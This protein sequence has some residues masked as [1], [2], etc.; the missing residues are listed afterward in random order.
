MKALSTNKTWNLAFIFHGIA[1]GMLPILVPLYFVEYLKGSVL[2]FGVMSAIATLFS[3]LTSAYA[4]RLPEAYGRVKPFILISFLLSSAFLFALARTSNIY[5]FQILYVLLGVANSLYPSSA[6]ILI[7]ETYQKADWSKIF[8]QHNLI[9]GLSN[10]SGLAICSLYVTSLG[11]EALLLICVPLVLVS[12]LL[13]LVVVNDP[14]FYVERLLSRLSRV[15]A[16]VESFSYWLGS[17]GSPR[18]FGLKPTVNMA[19]FG[20]GTL[21]FT[22]ASSAF[23]SSLSIFF[24]SVALMA[25]ATIFAIFFGRSLIGSISYIAIGKLMGEEG[26][27]NAVKVASI[28][29]AVLV[30]LLPSLIFLPQTPIAAVLLLSAINFSW[31]V[32]SLG[33][34]TVVMDYA[35]EGSAGVYD[36]LGSLGSVVGALL[37]GIIPAMFSF[38][39]LFMVASAMFVI[40]FLVFWKSIS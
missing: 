12:F 15:A 13:A 32:Y 10:T 16:E 34:S 29:R 40:A 11:Y 23:G 2:D 5:L 30:F 21:I 35:A 22:L 25:P 14:P 37:S 20:L 1:F 18:R 17:K 27:G 31:S 28:A 19:L 3:I 39:L 8:A 36:A 26:G 24:S 4:G 7:A 6:R 9:V 33:Y 38:N